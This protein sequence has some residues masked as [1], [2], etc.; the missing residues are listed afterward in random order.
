MRH[1]TV[2]PKDLTRT[3]VTSGIDITE[4]M[5]AVETGPK[6]Q[7]RASKGNGDDER[8]LRDAFCIKFDKICILHRVIWF[9]SAKALDQGCVIEQRETVL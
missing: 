4:H 6:Q 8:L 5:P 3:V 2:S 1:K 7:E 9:Q